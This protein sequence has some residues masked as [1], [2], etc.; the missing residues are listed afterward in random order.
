MCAFLQPLTMYEVEQSGQ[1]D[2]GC[3]MSG[4]K[5]PYSLGRPGSQGFCR[6]RN[7]FY[8]HQNESS[9]CACLISFNARCTDTPAARTRAAINLSY[10]PETAEMKAHAL[11]VHPGGGCDLMPMRVLP[12]VPSSAAR[13]CCC[14]RAARCASASTPTNSTQPQQQGSGTALPPNPWSFGFQCNERYLDWDSSAQIAL[15]KIWLAGKMD[16]TVP[17]VEARLA[18]LANLLPDLVSKM[19]RARADILY[20]LIKDQAATAERLLALREL[21][22]RCNVSALVA[23]HP[24]LMLGLSVP[25][26]GQKVHELRAKLPGV[27]VDALISQEPMLLRADLPRLMS[28]LARLMPHADPVRL[29]ARDPQ[30]VLDMDVAGM[31]STLE[32]DGAGLEQGQQ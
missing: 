30:M 17:E 28:E 18:E 2:P 11:S 10:L 7:L 3:H 9:Q 15:V 32:L 22:P 6:E 4:F 8:R 19:E 16:I 27:D 12:W 26:I 23:G 24:R 20:E 13:H 31:P 29:I 5:L 25:E 21:L 14:R 1:P